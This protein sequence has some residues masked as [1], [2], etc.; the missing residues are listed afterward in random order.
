[1]DCSQPSGYVENTDDCDDNCY[2]CHSGADEVCDGYDND[3]DGNIDNAAVDAFTY[4]ADNDGDGYGDLNNTTMDCSQPSGYVENSDDCDDNC[5]VCYIGASEVC[6]GIDNDCDGNT[7]NNTLDAI[8]YY[9]D[10]DGDTYGDPSNTILECSLPSG[11]VEN[12]DDCDDY[13]NVCYIGASEVCDGFDNDCDGN[14]DNDA[15]DAIAYYADNDGDSY[16]DPS[17]MVLE[18]SPPPGYVEND[19][20]CDDN[21]NVCYTGASEVC[22]G[23]DNDCDGNIDNDAIDANT[24]YADNDGDSYGDQNNTTMDCSVPSGY[25]EN[26]DDCDDND[27]NAW[28]ELSYYT[29]GDDDGYSLDNTTTTPVCWD[30]MSDPPGYV[31]NPAGVDCDDSDGN[32]WTLLEVY[33]DYDN[34]AYDAGLDTVCSN[35]NPPDHTRLTTLGPDCDDS[36][37]I[38]FPGAMEFCDG[39]DNDCNGMVDDG[40]ETYYAD[41]DG[42]NYYNPNDFKDTCALPIGYIS[43]NTA[44]GID[45]NDSDQL[46]NTDCPSVTYYVD[47][48][49]TGSMLLSGRFRNIQLVGESWDMAFT[50]LQIALATAV[51]GDTIKVA[52]GTYYPGSTRDS[53]FIIPSDIVLLGGYPM[54]GGT[55]EDRNWNCYQTILS[56]DMDNSYHV[57]IT[58]NVSAATFIEGFIIQGGNSSDLHPDN[59]GGGWFNDGSDP[60]NVSNPYIKNCIIRGN[61]AVNGG[62]LFN[63]GNNLGNAQA[64]LVNCL[65]S[66][67]S[68]ADGGGVFNYGD[69]GTTGASLTNCVI[70]GNFVSSS[71]GGMFN[72]GPNGGTSTSILINCIV[73]NNTTSF[74]NLS[75]SVTLSNSIVQSS[76]FTAGTIGNGINGNKPAGTDPLFIDAPPAGLSTLG[77]FHVFETSQAVD[78]GDNSA[79]NIA[80]LDFDLKNRIINGTTDIGI[81]EY[82]MDCSQITFNVVYVDSS[83]QGLNN[84]SSWLNAFTHLQ[85][86]FKLINSC[87]GIDSIKVAK[88]TYYPSQID[89]IISYDL[90][91]NIV[92]VNYITTDRS[93][94]FNIPDSV[95]IQGGYEGI[96]GMNPDGLDWFCNPTILSGN[97]QQ[98]NDSTNN[99]YHV[100]V[101]VNVD[102]STVVDGFTITEGQAD[103][104]FAIG[105]GWWDD[106][107]AGTSF[108]TIRNCKFYR[109]YGYLG[110]ALISRGTNSG[111][112]GPRI[113]NS[114][115]NGNTAFNGAGLYCLGF[116][117]N[118]RTQLI[119]SIISGNSSEDGPAFYNTVN[120]GGTCIV[121]LTNCVV[122][123]NRNSGTSDGAFYN[124]GSVGSC[125]VYLTNTIVWNNNAAFFNNDADVFV[126]YSMIQNPGGYTGSNNK[127]DGTD[128]LFY[129]A[130]GFMEAP[131]K[132]GNF[133]LLPQ[134]VAIDMG[135]LG[136]NSTLMDLGNN[137]RV[138]GL[139]IDIG[140]YEF[141]APG[142]NLFSSSVIYVDSSAT[143][144]LNN[145]NSWSNAYTDLQDALTAAKFCIDVDTIKVAQGTYYPSDSTYIYDA[146]G[147]LTLALPADRAISFDIPDSIKLIGG[148]FGTYSGVGADSSARDYLCNKTILSGD[149][150]GD[151]TFTGNS[152]HVVRTTRV[153]SQ[154]IVDGFCITGGNA[155][156]DEF[157][158]LV[159]GGW[160]NDGSNLVTGSNPTILNCIISGNRAGAGGGQYNYGDNGIC[161]PLLINCI[162]SG[163]SAEYGGGQY[164]YS[165][166]QACSPVLINCIISGNIATSG[167]GGQANSGNSSPQLINCVI[168]GNSAPQ[169]GG[170]Y[171]ITDESIPVFTNCILWNNTALPNSGPLFFNAESTPVVNYCIVQGTNN[172]LNDASITL[173]GGVTGSFNKFQ[174]D[175]LF[176]NS[177][178]GGDAP[179]TLGNFHV[180]NNSPAIDMG[181]VPSVTNTYLT[182]LDNNNRIYGGRID[183]GVYESGYYNCTTIAQKTIYVDSSVTVAGNG[184]SWDSAFS[185]LQ[186]ALFLYT[187]CP[188]VDTILVARGTYYPASADTTISMDC[189]GSDTIITALNSLA[190]FRLPDSLV[191]L[192]GYPSGGGTY[193]QRDW[194]VNRSIL[195]GD[196][197]R[198]GTH[199]GNSYAV[200][201]TINYQDTVVVDGFTVEYGNGIPI[202]QEGGGWWDGSTT[203]EAFLHLNHMTF[204]YNNA[205]LGGGFYADGQKDLLIRNSEFYE[206][207]AA[208][209]GGAFYFRPSYEVEQAHAQLINLV[210]HDN[211]ATNAGGGLA[212]SHPTNL[213]LS[214]I[215]CTFSKNNPNAL[216]IQS[217]GT[218]NINNSILWNNTNLTNSISG[219]GSSLSVNY[220]IIQGTYMGPGVMNKNMDPLFVH[221]DLDFHLTAFSP[222]INMGLDAFNPLNEDFEDNA[223]FIN[224]IDM[225]AYERA[226][227]CNQFNSTVYVDS[228]ATGLNNGL[229]WFNAFNKLQD[230]LL[231]VQLCGN[232][233]TIKV[234]MGTYYPDEGIGFMDNARDS[235]FNIPDSIV[236]LGGY[237]GVLGDTLAPRNWDCNKTI[238]CGD[239]DR[240]G[241]LDMGNSNNVI[242]TT[243]VSEYTVVD[244]FCISGGYANNGFVNDEGGGWFNDGHGQ[245]NSSN[246]T[247]LNCII[248]NNYAF[249]AGGGI[250]NYGDTGVASPILINCIISGN[251]TVF[252]GG[253]LFNSG[254]NGVSSPQMINCII[255]GNSS[256]RG[257]GMYNSA[258][259][260]GVSSPVIINCVFSGNNGPLSGGAIYTSGIDC[261]VEI[262]NSIFWNNSSAS[263]PVFLLDNGALLNITY[264]LLQGN[265]NNLNHAS[266]TAG[267]GISGA[268]NKFQSDG[269]DPLFFNAPVSAAAPTAEGDFHVPGNS[270]SIN[271]GLNS[272]NSFAYDLEGKD[273]ISSGIIDIGAYEFPGPDC[274][275]YQSGVVYVDSAAVDGA[276]NG[277]S[278]THAYTN[279]QDALSAARVCDLV[280]TIK[281]AQGTYYPSDSVFSYD[282]CSNLISAIGP[283]RTVSF[284]IQD[285]IK[286]IGGY[287]GVYS[288]AMADSSARD[289]E[290]NK[291]ILCGDIDQNGDSTNNSYHVLVTINVDS[292]VLIDGFCISG[293]NATGSGNDAFGG[294]FFNFADTENSSPTLRNCTITNNFAIEGAG[295]YNYRRLGNTELKIINCIINNNTALYTGGGLSNAAKDGN[296]LSKVDLINTIISGNFAYNHGAAFY[297]GGQNDT[298]YL[299]LTNSVING[300]LSSDGNNSPLNP[301]YQNGT[302]ASRVVLDIINSII[303]NNFN[304]HGGIGNVEILMDYSMGYGANGAIDGGHNKLNVDPQFYNAPDAFFAPTNEGD[305]HVF[306]GSP[307][308]NMG[309]NTANQEALDLDGK[310][311]IQS[312]TID[313]GPYEFAGPECSSFANGIIYVDSTA[314]GLNNGT[315]WAS[316]FTDLQD[317]LSIATGCNSIDTIKVAQ[318]T[319]Y[320]SKSDTIIV[321]DYCSG[322][323]SDTKYHIPDRFTSFALPGSLSLIGGYEG[324]QGDTLAPRNWVC[325]PTVLCGE[326]QQDSDSTNN[327]VHVILTYNVGENLYVEGFI[328][329]D[330]NA[331]FGDHQ[332]GG[333]WYNLADNTEIS[334][335]TIIYCLFENNFAFGG[336]GFTNFNNGGTANPMVSN[337]IFR[338]NSALEGGGIY[339]IKGPNLYSQATFE[340]CLVTGNTSHN[341][342]SK[343]SAIFQLDA[344]GNDS[345]D[346]TLINCVINGNG[347]KPA[348]GNLRGSE[349]FHILNTILWNNAGGDYR[350]TGVKPNQFNIKNSIHDAGAAYTNLGGNKININPGFYTAP[351][352][353]A[354]PTAAGNFHLHYFSPAINMGDN[355][356]S[357]ASTDLDGNPRVQSGTI[358]IGVYEFAGPDCSV[359]AGNVV[360]VDST[361]TGLNNGASWA[362]AYNDLQ[363]GL[364]AAQLCNTVDTIKVAQGIYYPSGIDTILGPCEEVIITVPDRNVF[365]FIPDSTVVLGGYPSGGSEEA[366]RMPH[367]NLTIMSGDINHDGDSTGNSFN[368]VKTRDY[369]DTIVYDG[370]IIEHGNGIAASED[371]G[372]WWDGSNHDSAFL[373]IRNTLFRNNYA[374]DGGGF[375]GSGTRDLKLISAEYYNN[376][377]TNRGGAVYFTPPAALDTAYI[378]VENNLFHHNEAVSNGGAIGITTTDAIVL[379]IIN[380]TFTQN[381]PDA[382]NNNSSGVVHILNSIL[383]GND[384]PP[385][386]GG[387]S[388]EVNNSIVE[389]GYGGM[390]IKDMDPLFQDP[391]SNFHLAQSSPAI[392]MGENT[393]SNETTDLDGLPRIARTII[394]MGAFESLLDCSSDT[395]DISA[396]GNIPALLDSILKGLIPDQF[397]VLVN[398]QDIDN[399][400]FDCENMG[401]N[402]L[403]INILRACNQALIDSCTKQIVI[404]NGFTN[405]LN[406]IER[407]NVSMDEDCMI[408]LTP[409]D[410]LQGA[411]G[412]TNNL[413]L[414]LQYPSGTTHY[415]P[416]NK[417]D[418]SHVGYCFVYTVRDINTGNTTWGEVCIEDKSP[419]FIDC[420]PDTVTCF[421]FGQLPL[422]NYTIADNCS[423]QTKVVIASEQFIDFGCDSANLMGIVSRRLIASD[424][425]G[426]SR[427]CEKLYFIR[428]SDLDSVV[429]PAAV[430]LPC[431][432]RT[433]IGGGKTLK[434][435]ITV[436]QSKVTPAYLLSLQKKTWEFTDNTK[437][438]IL[439]PSVQ[440]VPKIEGQNVWP[441]AG[442]I[443][444]INSF[445][446][447]TRLDICGSGFKIHREWTIVDWC[448]LEERTCIQ[449]IDVRDTIP[450]VILQ[451]LS[452]L[453]Y[454][455][456]AHDCSASVTI[457]A[458]VSGKDF[459]DCNLVDQTYILQYDD[460]SHPGKIVVF[461]GNLPS[462]KLNLPVGEYKVRIFLVDKCH[463]QTVT[464]RTIEIYD[465]T[466][467]TPV[468]DEITQVT[469]DPVT[470]WAKVKAK[471][472]DNGSR[473]NCCDVLHFAAAHMDSIT[474]WRKYWTDTL[475]ARC[476][477]AAFWDNKEFYDEEIERWI[478]AY[479]FKDE[480]SF[481]DCGTTQ[482]VLRV[483]EA[484][485]VPVY[486]PHLWLCT[487]HQWFW[488][489][490]DQRFRIEHNW[491]F[492]HKDGPKDCNYRYRIQCQEDHQIRG[493]V[494]CEFSGNVAK[495]GGLCFAQYLGAVESLLDEC[496]SDF[497]FGAPANSSEANPPGNYCSER[498]YSDCMINVLVDDKQ[499]PVVAE[500]EDVI[501]YCDRAPDYASAPNCEGGDE[502]LVWPG[503]LKDSKEVEHGYYGG[504][505]FLGIHRDEHETADA[506][507]ACGYDNAHHWAPIYCRSWLYVDSFDAAGQIDPKQYFETLVLF[508]K[509]RPARTLLAKEFS[510]TDNCRL[511]DT[512]LKVTDECSLN[513]CG[514]GWI[515]RTWTI[516]DK[517]DNPITVRQKVVVKHRSDFEVIFPE[518][519]VVECDF[520]NTT[521]P[522]DAG[523]PIISDDECEQVGVQYKDE[524][525][526]VED[527]ACYKIVR[528]WTLIDWCIY[529]PNADRHY[530][531]VIVDDRLRAD[532]GNRSCVYRHL[533]DNNDG[534]MKYIQVIKVIDKVAPVVTT[535]DTTIC[536]YG[537]DCKSTLVRIPFS[538]TDNCTA[539][540]ELSYRVEVDLNAS[541]AVFTNRTYAKNSIDLFTHSNPTEFVYSPALAGKHV[542]HEIVKDNCGNEDTS[543]YRFELKDCK[544]PT[545]YCYNGIATV[546]MPST[547]KITVRAKDL[548]AGSFDNCTLAANL[549]FSF[550]SNI[551]ESSKEFSCVDIPDGR[552]KTIPLDIWVTDEAGNQDHCTTYILLQDN[553]GNACPD[554]AGLSVTIA[555]TI[556]TETKEP[557]EHVRVNLYGGAVQ[558]N[559]QTGV[560]G[561]YHFE[562]LPSK[563]NYSLKSSRDD[564]PMNGIS[565][566]DLVL[567]QKHILGIEL[568]DSPYKILAADIDNDKQITAIDLV[569]LRKLILATYKDLP[570]NESWRFIPKSTVF[571]DPQNPWNFSEVLEMKEVTT[572]YMSE[573]FIGLKVGD[574]NATAAPHS[575]MGIEVR[576]NET[577][578][579]FEI[580]DQIFNRGDVVRVDFR[581]PN[582]R[583]ISGWQG[584][585]NVSDQ[586][587]V[588]SGQL[589]PGILSL[590]SQN[591]G[592]KYAAEGKIT[593]SWNTNA[594]S[595]LDI[596]DQ[597]VLFT[598][599]F[600]AQENGRLSEVLRIGSQ[601]TVAESYEGKGELGNLSIRF[602]QNGNEI[603]A[604]SEL[605]QNYPNPFDQRTVIGINLANQGR[606]TLKVYD[607]TGRTIKSVE[608]DWTKGYHE[609]WFDRKEIGATGV[610]YYRFE[611]GFFN[612]SKKMIIVD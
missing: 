274:N 299:Q 609:V 22:D 116:G 450:P 47:S 491:N 20:D 111:I 124:D 152:Y 190:H 606:G 538:G 587:S 216:D 428:K 314:T 199:A 311:R 236:L 566:L 338:S 316:A 226:D 245:G 107:N 48:S 551:N 586:L 157:R 85:S 205:L 413:E 345:M 418:R 36:C 7:D 257:G 38:C 354:A 150:D 439:N 260:V 173:G 346:L 254:S 547:G 171:N 490:T 146:C 430:E 49:S 97:I 129:L 101:T 567:I 55:E 516:R 256:Q 398:G 500:L 368:V 93:I 498:L 477:K 121:S 392:D 573:D 585:L 468:C 31:Y 142:C 45:C 322:L 596:D 94:S 442:G 417:V 499:A 92:D 496:N 353:S 503:L 534:Y 591:I 158:T 96:Q 536:I 342:S 249:S 224:A 448:T 74:N 409:A 406:G 599:V 325:N 610:L 473:D 421:E 395:F 548:D 397:V 593:M 443:C 127:P 51:A 394:D 263:G 324:N 456:S 424:D 59:A 209:R 13:C 572:D 42:D 32:V 393:Y 377:V 168:S 82:G 484:C 206:D 529:N 300:N 579:L 560:K 386:T 128:P 597:Q 27:G 476:G 269:A 558:M 519:K 91:G 295:V 485:G 189:N 343:A 227:D 306:P 222:G 81:F 404:R 544:K 113:Y 195:S 542:V 569:E 294:G 41:L 275:L 554:I 357:T 147:N 177:P 407:L 261:D 399:L 531:D 590:T 188:Q 481:T 273:R 472:L 220:S 433:Q 403:T 434:T 169:G 56:G 326:I 151:G 543:S 18:C 243:N 611:S 526:T 383:W 502:Y 361:A 349:R 479:V 66:G 267:G 193:E 235:S 460:P 339:M 110:G 10:N 229:S 303:W 561:T 122:S 589:E 80:S 588:V 385:I 459:R 115:I 21:C 264:S 100:V 592:M 571:A 231:T 203:D 9:R 323:A 192:G 72:Y 175:P 223:R 380:S 329:R 511:N 337:S 162:L 165:Y 247:I 252:N 371:G 12:F 405:A 228:S 565:T 446:R 239:I 277:S 291:T 63:Y 495:P 562:G 84:G 204:R 429:C 315:S 598:L 2:Y 213:I 594:K 365:F 465:I 540:S 145:G 378:R 262:S 5:N 79:S 317:A 553:S 401:A 144:G 410:V 422:G 265:S 179:T 24:Y 358:D 278:W 568:L 332:F 475:E 438:W 545:P 71:G 135:L 517:C 70:S 176:F 286:L 130:P 493:K 369:A 372:G 53:S 284:N 402:N 15:S 308:I 246:P 441:G 52:Q 466:P 313:I 73:W 182:D 367:C 102:S 370:F 445:L 183:I 384:I 471:D 156:G 281:V 141:I 523:E 436:D 293:G 352:S 310:P 138:D 530:A 166:A 344:F 318:G 242:I 140:S 556:Q 328:I 289:Y 99:S 75:A 76:G 57:V 232:I 43:L 268:D 237:A 364:L 163:N 30:G 46:V 95:V 40:L 359:F 215:N 379:N 539:S 504:S 570:N 474:Y 35:G 251:S 582:F 469:V 65:I 375:Y 559:Y 221:P 108:P 583:G 217:N 363:D 414:I 427:S 200:V 197:D 16:G 134:S 376:Y 219:P 114:I 19:D 89:T 11:Y 478:N 461:R 78:M 240:N 463:N 331:D 8:T 480:I 225:G 420:A 319:Y 416:P 581:S 576:G 302:G 351:L 373:C 396:D 330:G 512:T 250:Y 201:K 6:D 462:N 29:D 340:N 149:I 174:T 103:G 118:N 212:V 489:N 298:F 575:L 348:L 26:S 458:L 297:N 334:N 518:D 524:V 211:H 510:I 161:S 159:G 104:A 54:G 241:M 285:S 435:P 327:S 109:N 604:K 356:S 4:Y 506:G 137:P 470:C 233:D 58:K 305:F 218:T 255:S 207:S 301:L 440:V 112:S 125:E 336:G 37:A 408:I 390:N 603:V 234:A 555:G 453:E 98:D 527:S 505:D 525:F 50:S 321:Y 258:P 350:P 400:D 595:G 120:N 202:N 412:C 119:N 270:P 535:R 335:P 425:W 276:N 90:C 600:K 282:A 423:G 574:V 143:A 198:D 494:I 164:N 248:T 139:S 532:T 136:A 602:V 437:D 148:Y 83:A 62:G 196:I 67:N 513:G 486:D 578:L 180:L 153:N 106:G 178:V 154:T 507:A 60:N 132:A 214:I 271:M 411:N 557:V 522:K 61:S 541:D 391:V 601:H 432:I 39:L 537:E 208:D 515:Q 117:G 612:A 123:G 259:A 497:Y 488:Y 181:E 44:S 464:G 131:T 584:T 69:G 509:T 210:V 307:A 528:T 280:D 549:K 508:D 492:F 34:D 155:D 160:F 17:N 23:Y 191:M 482:V 451:D 244:G 28:T 68:A 320:P 333:G 279:L 387:V 447:D 431:E 452:D 105:G 580:N 86:A 552:S 355:A 514:E 309:L 64:T 449:Y 533:K 389:G 187:L 483:Y 605:Y 457:P 487:E 415:D 388:P 292:S 607:A 238:L 290:C 347:S 563:S 126:N 77:N 304:T 426:N 3:C 455:A 296:G 230:A 546:I 382:L 467:P 1:M 444:K 133:R 87:G 366:W 374:V 577:G 287:F 312:G 608:R 454:N 167:G 186:Q 185:N 14:T 521:D 172:D 288:G 381:I 362:N 184:L 25:V 360:Y 170:Q 341:L 520:L 33:L 550:S 272:A 501:V 283:D 88:G 266:I 564:Q 194:N 419:A 253:G